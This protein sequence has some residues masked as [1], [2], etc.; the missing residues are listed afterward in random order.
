MTASSRDP[1]DDTSPPA[2]RPGPQEPAGREGADE[3]PREPPAPTFTRR[4]FAAGTGALLLGPAADRLAPWRSGDHPPDGSSPAVGRLG[5]APRAPRAD[6]RAQQ[7]DEPPGTEALVDY[8]RARWGGR[9]SEKDLDEIRSS[10][11]G[12]LRA[13]SSIA[14]VPLANGDGPAFVFRPYRGES[15]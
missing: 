12:N 15:R 11:A 1:D 10:V 14:D 2:E 8:L 4:Q 9:L 6:G 3:G 13:A 5:R 7:E